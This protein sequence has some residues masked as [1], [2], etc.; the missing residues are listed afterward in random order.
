MGYAKAVNYPALCPWGKYP[1]GATHRAIDWLAPYGS[2]VQNAT[3][4]TVTTAGWSQT[5]FGWHV[6]VKY[7]DGNT[8]LYAH[9]S[10]ISVRVGQRVA[11]R[12]LLGYSGNS[13]N[14]TGPHLHWEVRSS[15]WNPLTSWNYTSK[16]EP[17][18]TTAPSTAP[19]FDMSQL[20]YRADNAEVK[21]FQQW[22]WSKQGDNYQDN[23]KA[24]VYDFEKNGFTTFYGDSTAKMVQDTYR[25]LA[26]KFPS[27][28]WTQGWV[29]GVPPKEP[30]NGFM[31]YFGAVP[32]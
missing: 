24:N 5:G 20:T 17:Y 22:L 30:G 15:S 23:F 29:N 1:S 9:L 12:Q 16:L 2:R 14:S 3:A 4:G 13:G 6:R 11:K 31:K 27:G 21:R 26:R 32:Y 10:K 28:G 18:S 8:G 25:A 7:D 19:R